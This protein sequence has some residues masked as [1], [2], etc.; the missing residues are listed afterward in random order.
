VSI[1]DKRIENHSA[2]I[3]EIQKH[4]GE[5]IKI[6]IRKGSNVGNIGLSPEFQ[7]VEEIDLVP[8]KKPPSLV[9]VENVK[10]PL[11]EVSLGEAKSYNNQVKLGETLTQ[12]AIGVLI[13][14]Q[15]PK[16]KEARLPI[17]E[18]FPSSFNKII[19]VLSLTTK[20]F[21]NWATEG[22]NPGLTGP[23]GIAQVTG[24]VAGMGVAPLLELMA[25]ISISLAIINILP[26]PALDGGRL[27]FIIIE[28]MRGGKRV[29]SRIES[30]VHM[31]GFI[32][33]IGGI[34]LMSYFDIIRLISGNRFLQ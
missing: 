20:G 1:N 7:H 23:I 29:S 6:V 11:K 25:L 30:L 14:T 26:I 28:E 32:I 27:L 2:L 18:A 34:L 8:R 24:E 4:L 10:D 3:Q 31:G 5:P 19:E 17:W 12:G 16:L 15:N 22:E 9:V 21:T 13:G 33:L